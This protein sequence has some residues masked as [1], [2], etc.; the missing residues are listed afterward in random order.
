M[1]RKGLQ[2]QACCVRIAVWRSHF[3][4]KK[5]R[6]ETIHFI[7]ADTPNKKGSAK[8]QTSPFLLLQLFIFSIRA[9]TM[10]L[11]PS[12]E[13]LP[14]SPCLCSALDQAEIEVKWSWSPILQAAAGQ[15]M[16]WASIF[17]QMKLLQWDW[18]SGWCFSSL[19]YWE[20]ERKQRNVINSPCST[21]SVFLCWHTW[22][23]END[24]V[25]AAF[26]F[27]LLSLIHCLMKWHVN[28]LRTF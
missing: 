12:N 10:E 1:F 26:W 2:C 14:C 19:S 5:L 16:V 7:P 21:P 3:L 22:Q 27:P 8:P 23:L 4:E 28:A 24:Q 18:F 9:Q 20:P 6:E 17:T 15:T 11:K 13:N 25:A